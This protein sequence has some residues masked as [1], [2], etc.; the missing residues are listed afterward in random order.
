MNPAKDYAIISGVK[1]YLRSDGERDT[2]ICPSGIVIF[3]SVHLIFELVLIL[4]NIYIYSNFNILMHVHHAYFY[5]FY[6]NQLMHKYISQH[7]LFI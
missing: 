3:T 5:F 2:N 1:N 7:C 4:H 6:F